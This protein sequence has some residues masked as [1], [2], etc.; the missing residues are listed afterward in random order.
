[1]MKM[2]DNVN[3]T[4]KCT[5][6]AVRHLLHSLRLISREAQKDTPRVFDVWLPLKLPQSPLLSP[7]PLLLRLAAS[8]TA[9]HK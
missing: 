5:V 3:A 8:T 4:L 7:S 1:M 9:T 6:Y 2:A